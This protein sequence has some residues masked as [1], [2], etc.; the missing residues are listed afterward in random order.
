MALNQDMEP[1][2]KIRTLSYKDFSI[3]K[4]L[5]VDE[6]IP[7]FYLATDA[8]TN[9]QVI[10]K[11]LKRTNEEI[12][13][14]QLTELENTQ[15]IDFKYLVKIIGYFEA[16]SDYYLVL[17]YCSNGCLKDFANKLKIEKQNANEKMCYLHS[18]NN[19]HGSIQSSNILLTTE[20][21]VR[22][23]CLWDYKM[24]K[25]LQDYPERGFKT[26]NYYSPERFLENQI[27]QISDIWGIG[28]S[29]NE[30]L[31]QKVPFD[32]SNNEVV[33]Q[34]IID[35]DIKP[36]SIPKNYSDKLRETVEAMI[37][38]DKNFRINIGNLVKIPEINVRIKEYAQN[39]I[40][41]SKDNV[42]EYLN[43]ILTDSL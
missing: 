4:C 28:I 40:E 23:S 32:G 37:I 14:K 25:H 18:T 41:E 42:K 12:L 26:L 24:S 29:I 20:N 22:L 7:Q 36:T 2:S 33:E 13:Q 15:K 17:E 21:D 35:P 6:D 5:D 19:I 34:N 27:S 43:K 11:K 3:T 9:Q 39:M 16:Q 38:K 31:T 8:I 1:I 10:L 30:L